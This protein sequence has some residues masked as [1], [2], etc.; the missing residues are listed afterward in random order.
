MTGLIYR[1]EGLGQEYIGSTQQP[2]HRFWEHLSGEECSGDLLDGVILSGKIPTFKIL[3]DGIPTD[4]LIRRERFHQLESF[5]KNPAGLFNRFNHR[6]VN[7]YRKTHHLQRTEVIE[8]SQH[9]SN[10]GN[11]QQYEQYLRSLPRPKLRN[12]YDGN[13]MVIVGDERAMITL[14]PPQPWTTW[15]CISR[16]NMLEQASSVLDKLRFA[17]AVMNSSTTQ[18]VNGQSGVAQ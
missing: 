3:E 14:P 4:K 8:W 2:A 9:K 10:G 17:C 6:E 5:H 15:N 1:I 18:K 13:I 11:W 12:S 7:E 16:S